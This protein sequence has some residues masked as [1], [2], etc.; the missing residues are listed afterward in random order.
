M[1]EVQP[2]AQQT[3]QTFNKSVPAENN[4]IELA[5]QQNLSRFSRP[6]AKEAS[7]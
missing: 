4:R 6:G 3:F 5:W 1:V 7:I 2:H